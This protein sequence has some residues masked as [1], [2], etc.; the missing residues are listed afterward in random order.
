MAAPAASCGSCLAQ[1]NHIDRSLIACPYITP[2]DRWLRNLKDLRNLESLPALQQL[3]LDKISS[4]KDIRV[5]LVIPIPIHWSR[6]CNRGYNQCEMLA[7]P[8]AKYLNLRPSRKILK[9]SRPVRSQ[10]SLNRKQRLQNQKNSFCIPDKSMAQLK[11][12][13]VLLVEDILTTGATVNQAARTL[14]EAG[15]KSVVLAAIARTVES[16]G[17]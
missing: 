16:E 5:N 13:N 9:R 4:A 2:L 14:K 6:R 3:L 7:K 8:L 15:A 12:K 11:G 10:R 1:S 17:F